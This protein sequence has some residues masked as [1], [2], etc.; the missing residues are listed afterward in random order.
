MNSTVRWIFFNYSNR[1]LRELELSYQNLGGSKNELS[2]KWNEKKLASYLAGRITLSYLLKSQGL[3]YSI[4]AQ[5]PNRFLQLLDDHRNPVAHLFCSISH[6]E[7][8][9]IAALSD[10]PVGIDIEKTNRA[11]A[12]AV[13]KI[14]S[15][16]ELLRLKSFPDYLQ[17]RVSDP[18]LFLWTGK[19]ALFKMLGLGLGKA[20]HDLEIDLSGSPPVSVIGSMNCPLPV[21]NPK[22]FYFFVED[23]LIAISAEEHSEIIKLPQLLEEFPFEG[24]R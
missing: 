19:E 12:R 18:N 11:A 7:N 8:V 1:T 6:T 21:K 3:N 15:E 4:S 13:S 16:N 22:I 10:C 17:A 9:S 2:Q 20:V 24:L 5:A 14:A 23:F